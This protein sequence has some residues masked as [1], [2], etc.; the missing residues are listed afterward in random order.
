MYTEPAKVVTTPAPLV[1]SVMA[2]PPAEVMI[3]ASEPPIAIETKGLLAELSVGA[4]PPHYAVD[5]GEGRKER[6]CH[7][8]R[9]RPS[10]GRYFASQRAPCECEQRVSVD[11]TIN[12]F[13]QLNCVAHPRR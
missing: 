1:A 9:N 12:T 2:S 6:T 13:E 10:E 7:V 11:R 3:V 8:S 4:S 5:L